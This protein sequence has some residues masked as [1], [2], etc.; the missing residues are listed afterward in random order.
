MNYTPPSFTV[1]NQVYDPV[2]DTVSFNMEMETTL[3]S[4]I[5]PEFPFGCRVCARSTKNDTVEICEARGGVVHA[6]CHDEQCRDI[7]CSSVLCTEERCI[8][9]DLCEDCESVECLVHGVSCAYC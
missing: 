5:E 4:P 8:H 2:T 6:D 9:Q 1:R 7:R 3:S